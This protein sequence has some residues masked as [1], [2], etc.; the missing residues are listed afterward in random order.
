MTTQQI[1]HHLVGPGAQY[2]RG[3]WEPDEVL[4][5]LLLSADIYVSRTVAV[6]I[7][8]GHKSISAEYIKDYRGDHGITLL[9][10]DLKAF[11]KGYH[12]TTMIRDIHTKIHMAVAAS[13]WSPEQIAALDHH[14]V[15]VDPSRD[16]VAVYIAHV[17]YAAITCS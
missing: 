6:Q 1:L 12:S 8:N 3:K 14:Y 16:Q 11:V 13:G 15:A 4:H 17:M 5:R 9:E 10:N 2:L 7:I